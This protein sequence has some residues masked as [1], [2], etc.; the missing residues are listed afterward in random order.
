[1]SQDIATG[2]T[3]DQRS[4]HPSLRP[5]TRDKGMQG[6]PTY[7]YENVMWRLV[8]D[9]Y[10]DLSQGRSPGNPRPTYLEVQTRVLW[11]MPR[12]VVLMWAKELNIDV[13]AFWSKARL[14]EEVS[15]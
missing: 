7:L 8:E 3:A 2:A 15:K 4:F 6:C 9:V 14:I 12:E 13:R 1:M 10:A 11:T 5:R